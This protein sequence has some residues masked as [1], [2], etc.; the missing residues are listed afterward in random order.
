MAAAMVQS[1]FDPKEGEAEYAALEGYAAQRYK[2]LAGM[3]GPF[4]ESQI[5]T[6]L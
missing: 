3:L 1:A 2:E 6:A 4:I 5:S